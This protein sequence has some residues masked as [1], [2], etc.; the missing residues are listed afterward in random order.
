[1]FATWNNGNVPFAEIKCEKAQT[2]IAS[3][4]LLV[5]H[6]VHSFKKLLSLHVHN[7]NK[8]GNGIELDGKQ[9]IV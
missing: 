2:R 4:M 6:N 3:R 5:L 8:T 9:K 1:M 7:N